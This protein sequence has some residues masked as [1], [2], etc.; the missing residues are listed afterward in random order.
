[1]AFSPTPCRNT[2]PNVLFAVN[3]ADGRSAYITLSPKKLES[4]DWL[5]SGDR[6]S[7]QVGDNLVFV[8]ALR[9][10]LPSFGSDTNIVAWQFV[11]E[12]GTP[13]LRRIMVCGQG[14]CQG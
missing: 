10:F 5:R 2:K 7:D 12:L 11:L 14:R 6:M 1:M 4:G 3:Y 9:L 13:E 8:S